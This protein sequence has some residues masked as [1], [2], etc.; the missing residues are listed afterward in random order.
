M[1]RERWKGRR[2]G[3]GERRG[4]GKVGIER[5]GRGKV[6][7]ERTSRE[8]VGWTQSRVGER[9]GEKVGKERVKGRKGIMD[10]KEG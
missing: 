10:K 1:R 5:T 3:G 8:N 7:E 4:R 6:G 2:R 9:E